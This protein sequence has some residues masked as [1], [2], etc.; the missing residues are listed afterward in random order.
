MNHDYGFR[1]ECVQKWGGKAGAQLHNCFNR[2][3]EQLPYFTVIDSRVFVVHGGL[4]RSPV[5]LETLRS[6]PFQKPV[7]LDSTEGTDAILFDSVWSDPRSSLGYGASARGDSIITFGIDVTEDFLQRNNLR[8]VVRSHEVPSSGE[9][10][11][12][13][14]KG[15]CL[16]IFS[17]SNYCGDVGNYG[18]VLLIAQGEEDRIMEHWAPSVSDL[19]SLEEETDRAMRRLSRSAKHLCLDCTPTRA[20]SG[21]FSARMEVELIARVRALVVKHK[22]ELFAYWS[23]VDASPPGVFRITRSQWREGCS[24][25]LDPALPWVKL[26]GKLGVA[27][28]AGFVHYV[29][30]LTRYRAAYQASYG[31]SAAGWETAVW[32][33]IMES[34]VR[35][36]LALHEAFAALDATSDGLVSPVEFGRLLDSCGVSISPLQARALLRTFAVS[37][38]GSTTARGMPLVPIWDVLRRLQFT[39]PVSTAATSMQDREAAEWAMAALHEI[40]DAVVEQSRSRYCSE[41]EPPNDAE[42]PKVRFLALWYEDIDTNQNGYLSCDEFVRAVSELG[43]LPSFSQMGDGSA[44]VAFQ[45][46]WK[47]LDVDCN[48]RVSFFELLNSL[49]W[50]ESL[51][52]QLQEDLVESMNAAI[53]FN[54]SLIRRTLQRFDV[55]QDGFVPPDA[56]LT[57][58][59]AV[60][61]VLATGGD[62]TQAD[63]TRQQAGAIVSSLPVETNGRINY[64]AFLRSFCIV[65]TEAP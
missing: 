25:V 56:F 33:H 62:H 7:P 63:L 41:G 38:S 54:I 48:N 45:S 4:T 1:D 11:E 5:D 43:P 59:T 15:R 27:D 61:D 10:Y 31:L 36:D 46:L 39:L 16:T 8:L 12:W 28:N 2:L 35:A 23:N 14:H 52:T 22:S 44:D 24:A 26:Q 18:A 21:S 55:D 58:L 47:H 49:T 30:F 64:E 50:E 60:V 65:D 17:A 3:F 29:K 9:G 42:W 32:G 19:A 53:F 13:H 57:A 51:G 34:L 20:Q 37:G 40:C 6:L